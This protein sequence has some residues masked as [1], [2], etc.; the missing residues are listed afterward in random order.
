MM[1][2]VT[3][4][5]RWSRWPAYGACLGALVLAPMLSAQ[6][7]IVRLGKGEARPGDPLP[8]QRVV[9]S[10]DR[11]TAELEKVG[12]G[13][14]VQM[15]RADFEAL[16]GRA[17]AAVRAREL[18][19]RLVRSV[20]SAELVGNALVN[21]AGYWTVHGA[22]QPGVLPVPGLNLALGKVK[23]P[24]GANGVL[25]ELDGKNLGLFVPGSTRPKEANSEAKGRPP[26]EHAFFFDWTLKGQQLPHGLFFDVRVPPCPLTILE[27]KLPAAHYLSVSRNLALVTG[28]L[29]T[30]QPGKK[31][32]R[33]QFTGKSQIDMLVRRSGEGQTGP[34]F[35]QT[36]SKV[37]VLP[38]KVLADF[39]LTIDVLHTNVA[40][41][42]LELD[43]ALQ[44]YEVSVRNAEIKSW[45]VKPDDSPAKSKEKKSGP[46]A[47]LLIALR[48]PFQGTLQ[49]LRVRCMSE[50][51]A[52]APWNTPFCRLRDGV[53][54]GEA[55]QLS[56]HPFVPL[57][58]WD[59]G[60]FRLSGTSVDAEGGQVLSLQ[61]AST[62]RT[63]PR[64]P[65][66]SFSAKPI[67][68]SVAE[69]TTWSIGPKGAHLQV[70]FDWQCGIGSS[71]QLAVHLPQPLQAWELEEVKVEPNDALRGWSTK[72]EML[73][74][75]L[76]KGLGPQQPIK[77]SLFW[78]SV[79]PQ[80]P[81]VETTLE[82]P[83]AAAAGTLAR[84][85]SYT[86]HLDSAWQAQ[87]SAPVNGAKAVLFTPLAKG[88]NT[89]GTS[90]YFMPF[91]G[92][93]PKGS[94]RLLPTPARANVRVEQSVSIESTA[95]SAGPTPDKAGA[96]TQGQGRWQ[97]QFTIEPV[98]GAPGFVD[99][100]VWSQA[101]FDF[102]HA[103]SLIRE[104]RRL[105]DKEALTALLA[106]GC[107][108]PLE[109]A[110]NSGLQQPRHWRIFF[111][112]PLTKTESISF[113]APLRALADRAKTTWTVGFLTPFQPLPVLL[114]GREPDEP[115]FAVP[116][117]TCATAEEFEGTVNLGATVVLA[118][119]G[120]EERPASAKA[121]AEG[122]RVFRYETSG[123]APTLQVGPRVERPDA[124]PFSWADQSVLTTYVETGTSVRHHLQ[125]QLWN[126]TKNSFTF[127]LP[128]G[129][130]QA[131]SSALDGTGLDHWTQDNIDGRL[132]ITLPTPANG[133]RHV[134]EVVYVSE[135]NCWLGP[136]AAK[137]QA[138]PPELPVP[139]LTFERVW[140][141]G[142]GLAP[143]T[144]Q[145]VSFDAFG[146]PTSELRRAWSLGESWLAESGLSTTEHLV[147][148]RRQTLLAAEINTRRKLAKDTTLSTALERLAGEL[149]KSQIALVVDAKSMDEL[150]LRPDSR[151][152]LPANR[153][154][155]ETSN[156]VFLPLPRVALLTTKIAAEAW[157]STWGGAGALQDNL[158]MPTAEAA[159][160]GRDPSAR[161]LSLATW[162]LRGNVFPDSGRS[163]TKLFE[164]PWTDWRVMSGADN[165]DE[166]MVVRMP[167][168]HGLGVLLALASWAV[169][170]FLGSRLHWAGRWRVRI[171]LLGGFS[172]LWLW[173]P[174]P[175][176]PIAL[177][178]LGLQIVST[179]LVLLTPPARTRSQCARTAENLGKLAA[180][181]AS[182]WL[183]CLSGADSMRVHG[184][185]PDASVVYL[186][187][188]DAPETS[189]ALAP[190]E[191]LNKLRELERKS[192][193]LAGAALVAASY[194]GVLEK[195][196]AEFTAH[197]DIYSFDKKSTAHI[198]LAGVELKEGAFLDGVPVFPSA[199][200]GSK[201]G[202]LVPVQGMGWHRLTLVMSV[203]PG[204]KGD[205]QEMRF[206]CP[207]L[208]QSSM[209]MTFPA[210]VSA[211]LPLTG[212]G[213]AQSKKTA[214]SQEWK[215]DLGR[216]GQVHWRWQTGK[217]SVAPGA[218]EVRE[219]YYWD[220]QPGSLSLTANLQYT[221]AKDAVNRVALT[222][223]EKI[224]VRT[225]DVQT[226]AGPA[227][228]VLPLKQWRVTGKGNDRQLVIDFVN[229]VTGKWNI[230]LG[231]VP[232]IAALAGPIALRLPVP[233]QT[234]VSESFLA[235]RLEG[236]EYVEKPVNLSVTAIGPEIFSKVWLGAGAVKEPG[237]ITRA[238]SFRRTGAE[239]G[240]V[241]QAAAVS[242]LAKMDVSW[243][244]HSDF[245]DGA[246]RVQWTT[247]GEPLAL[248][249]LSIPPSVTLAEVRGVGL[250]QWSRSGARVQI[251]LQQP[252][253]QVSL[254]WTGWVALPQKASVRRF[255]LPSVGVRNARTLSM[256]V[257][258]A[259]TPGLALE[260]VK[261]QH[262]SRVSLENT[263]RVDDPAYQ[264]SFL[265]RSV[266]LRPDLSIL[267]VAHLRDQQCFVNGHVHCQTDV[268][269]TASL[270]IILRNCPKSAVR[271]EAPRGATA[272]PPIRNGGDVSWSVA[273]TAEAPQP[274]RFHVQLRLDLDSNAAQGERLLLPDLVVEG[275]E[276]VDRWV[277]VVGRELRVA[278]H[279]GLVESAQIP[280]ELHYWPKEAQRLQLEGTV[281]RVDSP[282]WRLAL[283]PRP[284]ANAAAAEV[285]AVEQSCHW[286]NDGTW[287]HQ[288]DFL[289]VPKNE[290]A[291]VAA[292]PAG[293][294]LEAILW[295]GVP[296]TPRSDGPARFGIGLSN[297]GGPGHLRLCWRF[298][299]NKE[300]PNA[301]NLALP[302]L[303]GLSQP[304]VELALP[305]TLEWR[306]ASVTGLGATTPHWRHVRRA[307]AYEKICS[308]LDED[309]RSEAMPRLQKGLYWELRQVEAALESGA[310]PALESQESAKLLSEIR[311]IRQDNAHW[312]QARGWETARAAAEKQPADFRAPL[313]FDSYP[314]GRPVYFVR[315][316]GPEPGSITLTSTVIEKDQN[317]RRGV[318]AVI[319]A[320]LALLVVTCF[321][322]GGRWLTA[323]GPELLLAL[324]IW[325]FFAWGPSLPGLVLALSCVFVRT[326]TLV[327]WVGR[328]VSN[329]WLRHF[330]GNTAQAVP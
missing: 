125:F 51:L 179:A 167:F 15:P 320:A 63:M 156:L 237:P 330:P 135:P 108:S 235:Y 203:R 38:E 325:G 56:I 255:D 48:E 161:F 79:W 308:S 97:A 306:L 210:S 265:V 303:E 59:A 187:E 260:A 247:T 297:P 286:R 105:H 5:H 106:F 226:S 148:A 28:P 120:L 151:L 271:L 126:W 88:A 114:P 160:L 25:G 20:Y 244:V 228:S 57:E 8:I 253:K 1:G 327:R 268:R 155:W 123:P 35:T 227:S 295:N 18:G 323:L 112:T 146:A 181:A 300:A 186:L 192:P 102:L 234:R 138:A 113:S 32:W 262:L 175:L 100:T 174:A 292:L 251:W 299:D 225:V 77:L 224:E 182:V 291:L 27:I 326:L 270:K 142:R 301:P 95:E 239:G 236:W 173:L 170:A 87:W 109:M 169:S 269:N 206:F 133:R 318:E 264:G 304:A 274:L 147:E 61:S 116:L 322:R 54:R 289:L 252:K 23:A 221:A 3:S 124:A 312:A 256:T 307:R 254:E 145:A 185:G 314:P 70:Q 168:L 80:T 305:L 111:Q 82:F 12:K 132:R 60:Q 263:W 190:P 250:K 67:H 208:C 11:L 195:D 74:L 230:Q 66:C 24:A 287:L 214:T 64:R 45:Q 119:T 272:G 143:W 62:E 117:V 171:V 36:Q 93:A 246:A 178:P 19:P 33:L 319:V 213:N 118:A 317:V 73:I 130:R 193:V 34:L 281:W 17:A 127:T 240:I 245:A 324:V 166:L 22:G 183:L 43:P 220:L 233:T 288:A 39:E 294:R 222:L 215:L 134:L 104:V 211:A 209:D 6:T 115:R 284:A 321:P 315:Q 205:Y 275:A 266:A 302:A 92:P 163:L 89:G 75:D 91:R 267:T 197:F 204:A 290:S 136:L 293:A 58:A 188:G 316:A 81:G 164:G 218:L 273:V 55:L 311:Q 231:L 296:L 42:I 217:V 229:P 201:Q 212:L 158:Q 31:L 2:C 139:L 165:T 194:Q 53:D 241:L 191:L 199:A 121:P 84:R 68:A 277:A 99:L 37:S 328:L 52:N 313:P 248:V 131:L 238:L 44:P 85:G 140:R 96:P 196:T 282:Q 141:L 329:R 7:P 261:L 50:R 259:A 159:T 285:F 90:S 279:K 26:D 83:R 280:D 149:A 176:R 129:C 4:V 189:F 162:Q 86:I 152:A 10:P 219:A 76:S 207:K 258:L 177:W 283:Q 47:T 243:K 122:G 46:A 276:H 21:G 94:L 144:A 153:P 216:D 101:D 200:T 298:V 9:L 103:S 278:E 223:P 107:R 198:P 128:R 65:N 29:D 242:P 14:L 110:A 72:G 49:G 184:Q 257:Q 40:S 78:T 157:Q 71:H 154:F 69:H 16:V 309:A 180:G 30:E 41:L 310:W 202:Y 98:A 249:E 13:A 150:D 137:V 172:V 232:R